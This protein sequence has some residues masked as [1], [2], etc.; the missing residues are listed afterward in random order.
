MPNIDLKFYLA[1]FLRRLP[2]FAV[3][4]ALVAAVGVTLAAILPP[5][6][7]SEASLLVEPQQ[8]PGELAQTTV[9]VNPYEQAQIIEQRIM[10]RANLLGLAERIGLYADKPDLAVS[11]IVGD[12]RA[13]V[14]LIGFEP[15]VTRPVEVPGATILGLAF[16]APTA[17]LALTGANEL[18][19]LVMQENVRLRTNRAEDT[20]DFFKAEVERL[21]TQISQHSERIAEMKTA[22]V[23]ALPDSLPTRRAQQEREQERLLALEREEA[24]LKNQR[25]TVVWVFERTG[26]A[27]ALGARSVEEEELDAL[28]SQLAQ[29]RTIYAP[30]SPQIRILE[31][32]LSALEGLVEGQRAARALPDADG[33]PAPPTSELDVEIA[34]IDA[35]LDFI[36]EEKAI[37]EKTL[38]D[39]DDSIKATP[40]NEMLLN[41]LERELTS[42]TVQYEAA[43][44]NLGQANVGERIEVMSKGERFSLI[45]PPSEPLAPVR[46]KRVLIAGAGV[47]GGVGL[48]L[49]FVALLE[50]LNRS[51][52]RP[53]EIAERFGAQPFAVLPYI[54]TR[55]ERRWKRGVIVTALLVIVVAIPLGL[56]AVHT[57]YQPLDT[58]FLGLEEQ[59]E[60]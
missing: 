27:A 55:G 29:Q 21:E 36:A 37:I 52:R 48:G 11:E 59:P 45:E 19:N 31:N 14:E 58:L 1:V 50:M 43:V 34:P 47:V 42:L 10:T 44:A 8:I 30:R 28:K 54:R 5:T 57:L 18:V 20:S 25:A 60:L 38:A 53:V 16:E 51:I 4:A 26:R 56:L 24:A 9:P 7:R 41:G 39:L 12:M 23:D 17:A 3:I 2:Y 15:D 40:A 49:G 46:P 32:R 35:R 6:F 33:N 13:R 22:N